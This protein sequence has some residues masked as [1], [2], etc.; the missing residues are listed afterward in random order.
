MPD[1]IESQ[2]DAVGMPA[3]K[4]VSVPPP[5]FTPAAAHITQRPRDRFIETLK[6]YKFHGNPRP[7]LAAIAIETAIKLAELHVAADQL[8][9][10]IEFGGATATQVNVTI[11]PHN[12]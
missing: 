8:E 7:D 2:A 5:L 6:N 11:H 3:V 12:Y 10:R 4:K 1:E 9:A